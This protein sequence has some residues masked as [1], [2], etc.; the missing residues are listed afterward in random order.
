MT[1]KK[2]NL[3][4]GR[5]FHEEWVN[6]DFTSTGENVIAHNL[7]EGIPFPDNEF[8][9][10]YHSHVLEH[11]PKN[12][13]D[14]FLKECYR[15]LKPGG[16]LRLAI[17]DL[18]TMARLY[19]T[20]LEKAFDGDKAAEN[21]YD[22]IMLEMYDQ[23]VRNQSGGDMMKYLQQDKIN[24]IEFVYERIGFEAKNIIEDCRRAKEN[25]NPPQKEK[26]K[27]SLKKLFNKKNKNINQYEKIGQFRLGGEIH[28]W[29]YDRFSLKRIM[30]NNGFKNIEVKSAYESS[31]ENWDDYGLDIIDGKIR[32]PDSLFMEAIK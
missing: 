10:V 19:L 17:P 25:N 32:K 13:A 15:V 31:I 9:I 28:Q 11:F 1:S 12:K 30:T 27:F 8:D 6:V 16:V 3:G 5:H 26:K 21:D 7:M 20:N 23:T 24:N 29:M 18:E 22:W 4:C 2:L 14:D